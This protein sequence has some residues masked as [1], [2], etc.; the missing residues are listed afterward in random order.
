MCSIRCHPIVSRSRAGCCCVQQFYLC[1]MPW[2]VPVCCCTSGSDQQGRYSLPSQQCRTTT[3]PG[4]DF[5]G[6]RQRRPAVRVVYSLHVSVV[7]GEIAGLPQREVL[8]AYESLPKSH[9]GHPTVCRSQNGQPYGAGQWSSPLSLLQPSV[10]IAAHVTRQ[11]QP[12]VRQ[13]QEAKPCQ[14][15]QLPQP[16][17]PVALKVEALSACQASLSC[18]ADTAN[19][20]CPLR[21]LRCLPCLSWSGAS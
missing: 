21:V 19:A 1:T 7:W 16:L 18:R 14:A 8:I 13:S 20:L 15:G 11:S 10:A 2:R 3:E 12:V 9:L 5:S 6:S 17:Q 4:N